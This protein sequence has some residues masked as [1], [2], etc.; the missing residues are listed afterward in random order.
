MILSLFFFRFAQS[1]GLQITGYSNF[2]PASY[3]ELGSPS[4][5]AAVPLF[6]EERIVKIAANHNKTTAQVI[7]RWLVQNKVAVIPKSN[8]PARVAQNADIFDFVLSEEEM[9][10]I[11]GM[12]IPF[13]LND[14][15]VY[16]NIPIY[17]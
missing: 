15:G 13:R 16:A 8:D 7:L 12:N 9:V 10:T 4:A 17:A 1:Q 3:V 14:P 11:N 6:K 2:G 5:Q